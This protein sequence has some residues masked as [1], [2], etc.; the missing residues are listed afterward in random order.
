VKIGHKESYLLKEVED[1][2][3]FKTGYGKNKGVSAG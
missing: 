1:D 2:Q 3:H